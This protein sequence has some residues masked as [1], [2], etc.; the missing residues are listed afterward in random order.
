MA[1]TDPGERAWRAFETHQRAC[2]RCYDLKDFKRLQKD[3]SG[4]H[5]PEELCPKG[6]AM[7]D[8]WLRSAA[9]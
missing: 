4:E 6:R 8:L 7:I 5:V 3:E 2:V 1:A 9:T